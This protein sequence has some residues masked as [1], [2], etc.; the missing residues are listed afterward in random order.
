MDLSVET[1]AL[2][3]TIENAQNIVILLPE[4]ATRDAVA[5]AL[6]MYLALSQ[7]QKHVTIGYP[8]SPTV[9]WNHLV[10]LNKMTTKLG[11]KNFVISL[12]YQEGTIEKVSY[13]I[14]GNKFNLVI[15]PRPGAPQFDEKK[16]SYSYS[17]MMA[18]VVFAIEAPT[19]EALGSFYSENKQIFDEKTVV[20]VDN[21]TQNSQ[22]GKINIVRPTATIAEIVTQMLKDLNL[23]IDMDIAS[24]LYDGLTIG[25][26]SFAHPAVNAETFETAA[27]L[28]NKGAKRRQVPPMGSPEERPFTEGVV[29]GP[30]AGQ[31][32]P[33]WFKPKIFKGGGQLM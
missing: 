23:P 2:N 21:H 22:F 26:R 19:R 8:K 6:A 29:G 3:Q 32:P 18:D 9:A 7:S 28:L 16:V 15:E 14:E 24:N 12:D 20:V 27:F 30:E 11:N 5:S 17:G 4:N 13:N 1:G 25:S 10:G 31:P 33:D